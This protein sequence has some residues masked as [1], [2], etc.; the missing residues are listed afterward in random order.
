MV[1]LLYTNQKEARPMTS[2]Y[3]KTE[4]GVI[5]LLDLHMSS[6]SAWAV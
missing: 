5:G 6:R 4:A 2:A 1:L 3:L